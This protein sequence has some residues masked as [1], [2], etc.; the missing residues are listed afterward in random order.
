MNLN[1]FS[2][3][4]IPRRDFMKKGLAGGIMIAAAPALITQLLSCQGPGITSVKPDMDQQMLDRI[5]KLALGK[6][7]EFAEVYVENRIS[8]QILMEESKFKSK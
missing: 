3:R 1:K 7:G 8:R 6:G 2:V 4:D 5:I